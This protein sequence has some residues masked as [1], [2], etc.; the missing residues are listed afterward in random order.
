MKI[1]S[2]KHSAW[3]VITLLCVSSHMVTVKD[4][5][6]KLCADERMCVTNRMDCG[7]SPSTAITK[8]LNMSCFYQLLKSS[9]SCEWSQESNSPSETD[10]SLIFSS[11]DQIFSCQ[12]L[13]SPAASL[14]VTLCIKNSMTR[15]QT[16][17]KPHRMFLCDAMKPHPPVLTLRD[18]SADSLVVSWRSSGDERCRLRYRVHSTQTWTQVSDSVPAHPQQMLFFTIEDLQPFTVYTASVSCRDMCGIWS[19][20]SSDI[21][22]RTRDRA[23]SSPP[24]VC[25]R[26]ENRNSDSFLL[27]LMWKALRPHEAGG[28][29]LGYQ[30]SH[31]PVK[32]EDQGSIHNVTDLMALLVVEAGN[33]NVTVSAFNTAGYGPTAHLGISTCDLKKSVSSVKHLWAS[34]YF[35]DNKS[36][37]IQWNIVTDPDQ[38]GNYLVPPTNCSSASPVSYYA[39]QWRSETN[40]PTSHW[41]TED[42]FKTSAV[43]Q[44]HLDPDQSYMISIFPVCEQQCGVPQSLPASLQHGA[45]MEATN[46]SVV[47]VTKATVT[48]KWVWQ[49]KTEPIRVN[50]YRVMLRID[51][52]SQTLSVWPDQQQYTFYNL[53]PNTEYSVVLLADNVSREFIPIATGFDEAVVVATAAPLLLLAT[54]VVTICLLSRT[55]YKSYFFPLISSPRESQT[56]KWL[57]DTNHQKTKQRAVL[58]IQDLSVTDV[59]IVNSIMFE[60]KS[61][62]H[63]EEVQ[64]EDTSP[65][66]LS[67]IITLACLKVDM[68]Y[69]SNA[70]PAGTTQ[71]Q[72][73]SLQAY[74]PVYKPNNVIHEAGAP[75]WH[76]ETC[77]VNT[78]L[79]PPP[80]EKHSRQ[81]NISETSLQEEPADSFMFQK[82]TDVLLG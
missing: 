70:L 11:E 18:S 34:S 53:K 56:G 27:H 23:P 63:S 64:D 43:I 8:S 38:N 24:E 78:D 21:T 31:T 51:S 12:G 79:T 39:I 30:V 22:G 25:Y 48:V 3:T 59:L 66:Q 65:L 20:W 26:L 9:V 42:G 62:P 67:H 5:E 49:R 6:L 15:R 50:R 81:S 7:P 55:V 14:T 72:L 74:D 41:G 33:S 28:R 19:D 13:F 75:L 36:L 44:D 80:T 57:M 68:E 4:S 37:L 58:D 54:V 69:V 46:L 47:G 17:S 52:E 77:E 2:P 76:S 32:E 1:W 40:P 45:L 29:V 61:E 73:V 60:P 71:H 16:R 35:P 82:F 10:V